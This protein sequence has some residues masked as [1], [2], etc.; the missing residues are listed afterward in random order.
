MESCILS[1]GKVSHLRDFVACR[2]NEGVRIKTML[3]HTFTKNELLVLF[4]RESD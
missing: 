3:S 4:I 1:I 2:I